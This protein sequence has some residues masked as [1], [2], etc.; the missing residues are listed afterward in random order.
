MEIFSEVQK[1]TSIHKTHIFQLV[2]YS[3]DDYKLF[4]FTFEQAFLKIFHSFHAK[5]NKKI[6]AKFESLA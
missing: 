4:M 5:A 1:N 3:Q 6:P 2:K